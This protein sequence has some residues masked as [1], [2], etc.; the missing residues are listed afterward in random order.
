MASIDIDFVG[1]QVGRLD[2]KNSKAEARW[3]ALN[4]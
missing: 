1:A 2:C 4:Y 3:G